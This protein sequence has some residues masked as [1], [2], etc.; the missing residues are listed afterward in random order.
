MS[1]RRPPTAVTLQASDVTEMSAH[2]AQRNAAAIAA[3]EASSGAGTAASSSKQDD[4]GDK[5]TLVD[6]ERR[7]RES[8]EKKAQRERV[9][10]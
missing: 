2:I 5:D 8:K 6:S 9:G 1:I 7:D 3:R 10:A 4:R